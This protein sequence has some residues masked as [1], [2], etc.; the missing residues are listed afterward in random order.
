MIGLIAHE[1]Q[2]ALEVAR[3]PEVGRSRDIEEF[4]RSIA[5]QEFRNARCFET[6]AAVKV[7][8]LPRTSPR[9]GETGMCGR[10]W[11]LRSRRLELCSREA[12]SPPDAGSCGDRT[13]LRLGLRSSKCFGRSALLDRLAR[14]AG[15]PPA[16]GHRWR[17]R[18]VLVAGQSMAGPFCN[19]KLNKIDVAGGTPVALCDVASGVTGTWGRA[20]IS[21]F[22]DGSRPKRVSANG[23]VPPSPRRR[24]AEG[25]ST[26]ARWI[27]TNMPTC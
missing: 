12:L 21:P 26:W 9:R 15:R 20:G 1:L 4:F 5:D 6:S 24:R 11:R 16:R 10:R 3:A 14:Y 2:H 19:G 25:R 27:R 8:P 22:L 13:L 17:K 23:G 7:Q 18:T